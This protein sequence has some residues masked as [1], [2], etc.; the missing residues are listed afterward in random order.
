MAELVTPPERVLLAIGRLQEETART[1]VEPFVTELVE[2]L[3][4]DTTAVEL[5]QEIEFLKAE[6]DR[7]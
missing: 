7:C 3:A 1:W 2:A 6:A 4:A 5:R